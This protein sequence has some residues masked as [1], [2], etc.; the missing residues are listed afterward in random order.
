MMAAVFSMQG[1]GQLAAAVVALVT[2]VAFRK[3]L[4]AART[5]PDCT[6]DCQLAADRAWRIIV[7]F[8]ILPAVF[9]LYYR[10]T[11]PETPRFTFDVALDAE[12]A[13]SDIR[14]FIDAEIA[15]AQVDA[16][17]RNSSNRLGLE[18]QIQ[19]QVIGVDNLIQPRGSWSDFYTYFKEY[20]NGSVLFATMASWFFLDFAFFGLALNISIQLEVLDFSSGS[21]VY[22]DLLNTSLGNLILVC[23]GG[24]PGYLLSALTM[25]SLGR[26]SI[27]IGGFATLT[28]IF[29]TI[30]FGYNVFDKASLIALY[31][32]AQLFFNF[33]PNST[34]FI[35][36]AECFPT[37][38]RSTCHGLSA[39]SG[40]LGAVIIQV[41]SQPLLT[42][43]VTAGCKGAACSPFLGHLMQI[44]AACMFCGMIVSFMLPETKR[45]TL[46]VLAGEVA[47]GMQASTSSRMSKD[48]IF[49][50]LTW[51][52]HRR[53][54]KGDANHAKGTHREA[55]NDARMSSNNQSSLA[56]VSSNSRLMGRPS[57]YRDSEVEV[58]GKSEDA[59]ISLQDMSYSI[60]DRFT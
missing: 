52:L 18:S 58:R 14:I 20:R 48:G 27:Q 3:S 45:Q 37:R 23:A 36:P 57:R 2:T 16:F 6:G 40:K 53:G 1:F 49:A 4:S 24:M 44:F 5:F 22:R 56:S 60:S 26:K 43:G 9:A 31:I 8:G 29:V 42:K 28:V 32:L 33:G 51:A 19:S 30:G 46:E 21:T 17:Q 7:G 12:K 54:R 13:N 25:D 15:L 59:D 50:R 39:A 11:I 34:T 41:V 47:L 10:L 38:Y 55:E 35:V